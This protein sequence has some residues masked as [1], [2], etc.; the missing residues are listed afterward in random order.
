MV[1]RLGSKRWQWLHRMIY[2]IAP[3]GIL[4]FWWMKAGKNDFA[5]PILFGS[6]VALLLLLRIYWKFAQSRLRKH[7]VGAAPT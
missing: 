5:Q 3:L 2:I 1:K 7:Q 6:I 4:H